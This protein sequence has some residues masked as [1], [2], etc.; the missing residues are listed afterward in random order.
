MKRRISLLLALTMLVGP[1]S[2]VRV[3][4]AAED[5]P[6]ITDV[7]QKP[8][9]IEDQGKLKSET[10]L[11]IH[12]P[13]PAVDAWVKITVPGE[14]PYLQSVGKL[15]SGDSGK[16]VDVVELHQDGDP[17]S[18]EIYD[19]PEGSGQP[20][21]SDTRQQKKIRHW[22]IFVSHDMHTDIGYTDNQENL[23]R[24]TFPGYL[25]DAMSAVESTKDLDQPDR[26][27]YP[28]EASYMLLQSAWQN[29]NADWI[30]SLKNLLKD[31][32]FT[33]PSSY[34]NEVYG[35]LGSEELARMSYYSERYLKDKLG[36]SSNKVLYMSDEPSF[37]W[38]AVDTMV[39]SGVKYLMLRQNPDPMSP[40]PKLFYYQGQVP[41][42]KL[43]AYNYGH[44]STDEM[45]FRNADSEVPFRNISDK[46][47]SY[48]TEQYPYDA[49]IAD[50]TT[51]YDNNG[52]TAAVRANIQNLNARKDEAGRKYVYPEIITSTT[53][54]FF[55]YVEDN[56]GSTIPT[57]KGNIES[58]WDYGVSSTSYETGINK[59]NHDKLPAA[60]FLATVANS[61][62]PGTKYPYEDLY[63][64]YNNMILFDEHT[65]GNASP[66][67]DDQWKWKRNTAIAGSAAAD[68][69]LA[70]S[71]ASIGTQIPTDG[72]SIAVY[73]TLS[74]N[75]TDLV[76]TKG[77]LFPEHFEIIDPATGTSV[78][79]QKLEDGTVAFVASDVPALGYKT[80]EI[81]ATAQDPVFPT[82][83]TVTDDTL[84]NEFYKV[85][86]D[87]TGAVTSIM[88]K[89][90]GNREMVDAS[91]SHKLNDFVYYTTRKMGPEV[92][93]EHTV[94]KAELRGTAG[95]VMATM[96]ADGGTAGVS[97]MKRRVIL[98]DGIPRID[99]VNDV[100][101]SE[102]P[103]LAQMDEEA[104][105]TFP[106]QMD[107]FTLRHE[108]PSGDVQPHV[109][110]N[111][112]NRDNEQ[113]YSSS[114]AYYAVNR[115]I[116]A[117]NGSDYGL[118]LSPLSNPIVEYGERRSAIGDWNYNTS[119]PWIYSYVFNNKWHTNF[120]KTQPGPVTFKYSLT[121]HDGADWKAGRADQ[122]GMAVSNPLK[123]S[124][125]P[126]AQNNGSLHKGEG[127][128]IGIDADN[129]AL[130]AAKLAE[131]NGE[132]V[133]LR[134]NET[135][136]QDTQVTVDLGLL[137]PV[138]VTET[139]MVENDQ[140]EIP[141]EG[142]KFT[143]TIPGHGWKTVRVKS[144]GF[145]GIVNGVSAVADTYGTQITWRPS[146]QHD[147]SYYEIFRGT[148]D[149]FIPGV[150]TYIGS[151]VENHFLDP[152]VQGSAKGTFYYKIRAVR[153]GMK[154]TFSK[155]VPAVRG[156]IG[157]HEAPAA[158]GSLAGQAR[159][160]TRVDL[161]WAPSK[162]NVRV[163]GYKLYRDGTE[164]K[165]LP[166]NFNS[167]LDT[168]V[169]GDQTYTYTVTAYD[170][171][172]NASA[173]SN[174]VK[175]TT[176]PWEVPNGNIARLAKASASS[177]FNSDY[178]AAKVIDGISGIHGAGEWASAGE[179]NPSIKLEWT[180]VRDVR[181]VVLYDR[182][183]L[184][185]NALEGTLKF[186]DGS[187]IE[188]KD[189]PVDGSGKTVSF[190][191][192]HV[193]WI[194][195]DVTGGQGWNVGLSEIEVFEKEDPA[196]TAQ[197]TSST[198][199][200]EDYSAAK[201]V[202]GIIGVQGSGEWASRGELNPWIQLSWTEPRTVS[203]ITLYDRMNLQD[204]ANSGTLVFS[205]GSRI[206]V[207][208]IPSD[209]AGKE[210]DFPPKTVEWVRFEVTGGTGANVGLSEI[211]VR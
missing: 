3:S 21:I 135:L 64:A 120:Q 95:P 113:F 155:A 110:A 92:Y 71:M 45:D 204:D 123:V 147:I 185:D 199:Y 174:A 198:E 52:I 178:G 55:S 26:F 87:S 81:R 97:S 57:F 170:D 18:F 177:E 85:T 89:K 124:I 134:F 44:Y 210:I 201:A 36:T 207:S 90:N 193:A 100:D 127:S 54:D 75:R 39:Q 22:K 117:S 103:P 63:D 30:E 208:G 29:R 138:S 80:F 83:I 186:S 175:V 109:D 60:E 50:F 79:Y 116:D 187:T 94:E 59:E 14:E 144:G 101:K 1:A 70:D 4:A 69:I 58:W 13:G 98:Y 46:L 82:G 158:P 167:F 172:G 86:F 137:K 17:V 56:F 41:E 119:K 139:D 151:T 74:W 209:G 192:K 190:P 24:T 20:F 19:N 105:F 148:D 76:Q 10:E 12:N 47:L 32:S 106:L 179:R 68:R 132:G 91:S 102:A 78:K 122:F 152:Q 25:D 104:F 200:N 128:F 28:V 112:N 181:Q 72:K 149:S 163:K 7:K 108:M 93:S 189:I 40:Y 126:Q 65:W 188:V 67:P 184:D 43:L 176:P 153:T 129:V 159:F 114:T 156:L 99:I 133:I 160:G 142:H 165:D 161:S 173:A 168:E 130:T 42:N 9:I 154:G 125:I 33:Y 194:E 111:I 84:E 6:S 34:V 51:P 136:G 37:S 162:D 77:E 62:A 48:Q 195:F 206:E 73:N 164:I 145:P 5:V 131:A 107:H 15:E 180:Q 61:V 169:T 202:D 171:A 140:G 141:L 27:R 196:K 49:Y 2:A 118:T 16:P 66:Q 115:W 143:F 157:D 182:M 150:G 146:P 183:N 38:P 53:D 203:G 166:A 11:S 121:S 35:T 197:V 205:D 31:K 88:D 8:W 96:T 211:E 23:N 191:V